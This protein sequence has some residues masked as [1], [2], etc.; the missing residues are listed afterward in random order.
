MVKE[1]SFTY[2]PRSYE[3]MKAH[4][5]SRGGGFDSYIKPQY[6]MYKVK[7]GKNLIRILPPPSGDW[8]HYG[9]KIFVNYG[10]GP[11]RQSYLSLSRMLNKRDPL[12]E[13]RVEADRAGNEQYARDLAPKERTLFWLIDRDD[14]DAGPQLWACPKTVDKDFMTLSIDDDTQK[15]IAI[16][17]PKKGRDVRFH[18][19]K[20]GKT[21]PEYPAAKIKLLEPSPLHE[22]EDKSEGWIKYIMQNQLQDTLNYYDYDHIA[23]V[24]NGHSKPKEEADES[25]PTHS[26]KAEPDDAEAEEPPFEPDEP[27]PKSRTRPVVKEPEDDEGDEEPAPRRRRT[28]ASDEDE[29]ELS[30]GQRLQ[31]RRESQTDDDC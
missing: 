20:T 6:K 4:I 9:L 31:R 28:A 21:Y 18:R 14:E 3:Q 7:D 27:K 12:A 19:E 29:A 15:V 25:K 22:D 2:K 16:D 23:Q 1:R 13:A 24:F 10:V 8:D 26:R 11:D 30:I 17:D 5:N